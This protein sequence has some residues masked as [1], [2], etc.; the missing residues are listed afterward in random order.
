MT[1][2]RIRMLGDP[3][4]RS[5][6]DP[7]SNPRSPGA[8]LVAHDLTETLADLRARTGMGRGLAAPQIGA[9]IQM[10][11][12]DLDGPTLMINPEIVDIGTDDFLVWDDC[13]SFPDLMVQVQRALRI[14]VRY[15]DRNGEE[16]IIDAEG[17]EAELLQHEID[18]LNGMLSVD[19]AAGLDPFCLREEWNKHYSSVGRYGEAYPRVVPKTAKNALLID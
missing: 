11:F 18:H 13:F 4:L 9:P 16:H 15:V 10:I 8:K 5:Q 17:P 14:Q 7:V 3:I 19:S 6:C 12:V 1:I 2:H